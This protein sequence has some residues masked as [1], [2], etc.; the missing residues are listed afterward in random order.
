MSHLKRIGGLLLAA[1]LSLG[2]AWPAGAETAYP[3]ADRQTVDADMPTSAY[4]YSRYKGVSVLPSPSPYTVAYVV[5]ADGLGV[6]LK[7]PQDVTADG[8]GRFYISNSGANNILCTDASFNLLRVI[9]GFDRAGKRETFQ[10]PSGCFVAADGT[11][12]IADTDNRRVVVLDGEGKLVRT[13][14]HPQADILPADFEF[15][16][17]KVAVDD[18]GRIYVVAKGVYEGIM[19]FFE[20]GAFSGFIGS[21]PVTA[22]PLEILWRS[23][24][25]QKQL[26]KVEQYIPVEYTNLYLDTEGFIYAVSL[27]DQSETPI[28]RLNIAGQDILLRNA[29]TEMPVAGEDF[30]SENA[31]R[32]GASQFV[33]I[34]AQEDGIYYALDGKR[35]R[36]FAYDADG[37]LLF[38]FGGSGQY[39]AG[40][41]LSPKAVF[42]VGD[43][44]G[45][46][47]SDQG[48]ITV[49][50][51]TEYLLKIKEGLQTYRDSRYEDSMEVW[52]D[53]LRINVN[54]DLAY[55]KIGMS[56]YRLER[57]EE[58]MN[59]FERGLDKPHYSKAFSQYQRLYLRRN[60]SWILPAV[61]G[62]LL[63]TA[64]AVVWIRRRRGRKPDRKRG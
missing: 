7:E 9:D 59:Y 10:N 55:S 36:V 42:G 64:A 63:F 34:F 44:L 41:F 11:L 27:S 57:Y 56:L 37:N 6:P 46:L 32:S 17:Q 22:N 45:V 16:P 3:P 26:A 31:A 25:S 24:M 35:C 20:D 21:M 38:V 52:Q 60:L 4:T 47:D 51:P 28:R 50:R 29:L 5:R 49:F 8:Q 12:Y 13:V 33:D 62:A 61:L 1:A 30:E 54:L 58:A 23:L 53:V 2:A 39:Q 18:S 15:K 43:G 19:V 48:V 14:E 40:T